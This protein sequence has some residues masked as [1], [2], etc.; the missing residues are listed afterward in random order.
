VNVALLS[1]VFWPEVRRGTERFARELADGLQAQ[2]HD[3]TIICGHGGPPRSTVEDGV[4]VVRVPRLPEGRLER[5]GFERHLTHVPFSLRAL[6][7]N[8]PDVAH[9]LY[10]SDAAGAAGWAQVTG[11]PL[12]FSYMGIPHRTALVARRKRLGLTVEAVR[13]AAATCVLSATARDAFARWLGVEAR[14]IA[15]G[16]DLEAFSP[17][18]AARAEHPTILC[19]ADP[20]EPRK[21]VGLLIEAFAH[22]RRERPDARLVLDRRAPDVEGVERR[23]LDDRA[24]LAA[25]NREA[26][27]SVLPSWGEAFGLVLL[28]AMACGTP[29]VGAD[30]EAIPEVVSSDAIGRL[31]SGDDPRALATALLEALEL[32]DDPATAAACRGHAEGYSWERTTRAYLDLYEELS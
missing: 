21:R 1:P 15:P 17:D 8:D 25:A 9:A 23:D 19:A 2:G 27:V 18:P 22:V 31:F 26:W 6:W 12:V 24:A 29:V 32:A 4:A 3:A 13:G 28:E 5:R 7:R 16:V 10:P 11:K 20:G 30:R 14:V